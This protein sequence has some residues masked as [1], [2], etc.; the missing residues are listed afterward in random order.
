MWDKVCYSKE[1]EGLGIRKTVYFNNACLAKL[2]WKVLTDDQ[3]WWVHTVKS[4]Y[5]KNNDFLSA[6]IRQN[7]SCAWKGTLKDRRMLKMDLRLVVGNGESI[8]FW[9]HN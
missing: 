1:N 2:S 5:L 8:I 7:Y 3:N 6:K 4:N 9:T